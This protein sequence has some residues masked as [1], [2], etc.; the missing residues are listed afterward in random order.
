MLSPSTE[1]AYKMYF[2]GQTLK[3]TCKD[4]TVYQ[5]HCVYSND[6]GAATIRLADD[7]KFEGYP[8]IGTFE[9]V[10][11]EALPLQVIDRQVA[12]ATIQATQ[13]PVLMSVK[14]PQEGT[15]H[16]RAIAIYKE[17]RVA[18]GFT[19]QGC[20]AKF[21]TDLGM[22]EAGAS[23]YYNMCKKSQLN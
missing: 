13:A 10:S 16:A 7:S 15:K 1:G 18:E 21:M 8:E 2:I 12:Q 23:T 6:Q 19:R 3:F 14:A 9:V 17:L 4:G 20:I 5:G 22:T 11:E